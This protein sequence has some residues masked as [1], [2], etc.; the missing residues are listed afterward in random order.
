LIARARG[1]PR[2][3]LLPTEDDLQWAHMVTRGTDFL[4]RVP[5]L[6]AWSLDRRAHESG[7]VR[8]WLALECLQITGSFKVRGAFTGAGRLRTRGAS[9]VVAASAGNHGAG[10]AFV[11]PHVGI[12]ATIVVPKTA[13]RKKV[14]A[15]RATGGD[16]VTLIEHGAGYDEAEAYAKD[17]AQKSGDP[18]LSPYDDVDVISGNGATLAAEIVDELTR[19]KDGVMTEPAVILAPFGGGGLATGLACGLAHALGEA[20]GEK[21]RVWGVQGDRSPAFALSLEQGAAVTSLPAVD[22]LAD[23]LEGGIAEKAFARA[24]G[25]VA[26]VVVVSEDAIAQA[27]RVAFRELGLAIEGSAAAALAP[28]LSGLP[29]EIAADVRKDGGEAETAGDVVVVLSGRNVDPDRL[30]RVVC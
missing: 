1:V 29:E 14:D 4:A 7:D 16:S 11:A 20:Y 12:A 18:F 10:L 3:D 8:V 19:H 5:L 2:L 30:M 23:G 6:R 27:M 15:I 22:T 28:V 9:R 26:G 13:P 21:R 24:A 25:V 17:L